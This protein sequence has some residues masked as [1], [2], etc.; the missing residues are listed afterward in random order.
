MMTRNNPGTEGGAAP[1]DL[2]AIQR[3]IEA[4]G[5]DLATHGPVI[6]VFL[7][8][9][10]RWSRE[11]AGF[12]VTGALTTGDASARLIACLHEVANGMAIAGAAADAARVRG[13]EHQLGCGPSAGNQ[14]GPDL[15]W[16]AGEAGHALALA[17]EAL[18]AV[19]TRFRAP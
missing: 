1:A 14:R 3:A 5:S 15:A 10:P 6:E 7:E 9:A 19:L 18:R 8:E 2:Q 16:I 11:L 17:V 13:L 4:M 12:R